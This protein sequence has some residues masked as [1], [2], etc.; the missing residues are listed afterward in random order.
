M[1]SVAV[2]SRLL[3]GSSRTSFASR[4]FA[5]SV[6]KLKVTPVDSSSN[7][8]SKM[9][10]SAG[11]PDPSSVPASSGTM[12]SQQ[13]DGPRTRTQQMSPFSQSKAPENFVNFGLGQPSPRLLPLDKFSAAAQSAFLPTA[14]TGDEDSC[15]DNLVLQYGAQR[16][17]E[18]ILEDLAKFLTKHYG[19]SVTPQ[20]LMLTN[21]NS[22]AVQLLVQNLLTPEDKILM[23]DP[24]YFLVGNIVKRSGCDIGLVPWLRGSG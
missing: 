3:L 4:S 24:T 22:H 17:Y 21:G 13:P 10:A 19:F 7:A 11:D 14:P 16:G 2:S 23:D 1:S 6:R 15:S 20:E 18:E 9:P 12:T 8:A 5:S